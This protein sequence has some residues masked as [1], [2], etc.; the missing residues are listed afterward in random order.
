M[1]TYYQ[2]KNMKKHLKS[3]KHKTTTREKGLIIKV[4]IL[5]IDWF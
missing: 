5:E 4:L 3:E 2:F 1:D